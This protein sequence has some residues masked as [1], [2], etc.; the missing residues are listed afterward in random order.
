MVGVLT[1]CVLDDGRGSARQLIVNYTHEK[2]TGRTSSITYEIMG[3]K[4]GKQVEPQRVNEKKNNL[5]AQVIKDSDKV[6]TIIDL[7]GHETYLKTTIF[8]LTGLMPDYAAII[9]GANMGVQRMTKEHLGIALAL[10]IPIFIIVT[11]IDI[12]PE[13]VYKQTMDNLMKI[14]R[15]P[16]ANKMPVMVKE[17]DDPEIFADNLVCDRI[18]PIFACSSVKGNGINQLRSFISK[19]VSRNQQVKLFKP[20]TDK[21]EFTIDSVFFVNTVGVV[22]SGTLMGG[23]VEKG[24]TLMLGP[25]IKGILKNNFK[26]CFYCGPSKINSL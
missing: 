16:A 22:V 18:C 1:K 17:S 7:C 3:F 5:W 25:D 2:E 23:K 6:I 19:L 21:V 26:R 9:V 10:K 8:G 12:A 4:E 13:D 14:L 20:S 24:Q 11:K 15:S